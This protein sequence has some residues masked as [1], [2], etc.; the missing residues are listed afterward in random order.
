MD[1]PC[2]QCFLDEVSQRHSGTYILMVAD[3]AACHAAKNL[4]IPENIE[5]CSLPPYSPDLNPQENIWDEIREKFF[6]NSLFASLSA[7]EDRLSEA[8]LYL[9]ANPHI[10]Q[11]ISQWNWI[12][13]SL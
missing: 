3:G 2:M 11:S 5:L 8:A 4:R 9:D 1:T 7:V 10:V 12:M 6:K 13:Q